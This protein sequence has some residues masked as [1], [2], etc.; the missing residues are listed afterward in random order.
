[1]RRIFLLCQKKATPVDTSVADLNECLLL[2]KMIA[3]LWVLA[4]EKSVDRMY[5]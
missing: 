4:K 1:M 5:F 3:S 2:K